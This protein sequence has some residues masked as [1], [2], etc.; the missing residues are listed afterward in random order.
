VDIE[1]DI[2]I[3]VAM[4][5]SVFKDYCEDMNESGIYDEKYEYSDE[6]FKE[7]LAYLDVDIYDW[8][9]S[10]LHTFDWDKYENDDE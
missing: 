10:N 5:H 7:F 9:E 4:I 6:K 8:I 1:K 2:F 3:P